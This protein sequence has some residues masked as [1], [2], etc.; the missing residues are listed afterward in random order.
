[1]T[2]TVNTTKSS[3]TSSALCK[4]KS[5]QTSLAHCSAHVGLHAMLAFLITAIRRPNLTKT[6]HHLKGCNIIR[7][8]VLSQQLMRYL[9]NVKYYCF[10][11]KFKAKISSSAWWV[12]EALREP[13]HT[14]AL[15]TLTL[16]NPQ[17]P[18]YHPQQRDIMQLVQ[19]HITVVVK[20]Q[21]LD[22]GGLAP[23]SVLSTT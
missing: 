6:Q 15:N 9:T 5:A 13:R 4:D 2:M 11:W 21:D 1:M 7:W 3:L 16:L 23:Q 12:D 20:R 14:E 19:H 8:L 18:C 17:W 10:S 22:L